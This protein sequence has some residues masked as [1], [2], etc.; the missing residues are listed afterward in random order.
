ML[1]DESIIKIKALS[2]DKDMVNQ[3]FSFII[4][5]S[6]EQD[7]FQVQIEQHILVPIIPSPLFVYNDLELNSLVPYTRAK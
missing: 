4:F 5:N 2:T 7:N 3:R 6:V 1:I